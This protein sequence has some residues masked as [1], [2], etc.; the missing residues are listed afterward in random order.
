MIG[1]VQMDAI[2]QRVTDAVNEVIRNNKENES[3]DIPTIVQNELE[4]T[5]SGFTYE[6]L[7][8][9]AV[10]VTTNMVM[11]QLSHMKAQHAVASMTATMAEVHEEDDETTEEEGT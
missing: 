6:E 8:S 5:L 1:E 2:K 11:R 10:F 4:A 9:F 3:D 7:K